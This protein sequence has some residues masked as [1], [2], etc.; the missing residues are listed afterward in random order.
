MGEVPLDNVLILP[1][2]SGGEALSMVEFWR[3]T[4]RYRKKGLSGVSGLYPYYVEEYTAPFLSVTVR[5]DG[6]HI[7]R[8]TTV[9]GIKNHPMIL[10]FRYLLCATEE[11]KRKDA[12]EARERRRK[13]N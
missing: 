7:S 5:W 2:Q 8:K 9:F 10:C 1:F 6:K 4:S 13:R 12:E 3:R 11:R